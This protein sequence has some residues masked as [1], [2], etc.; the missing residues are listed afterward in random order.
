LRISIINTRDAIRKNLGY[1]ASLPERTLR[2]LA[3]SLGGLAYE[4][5]E[6]LLPSWLRRSR[7][8]RATVAGLLRIL[9]ELVGGVS[10]ALPPDDVG[11]GEFAMRKAAGT[12]IEVAGLLT[13]GWSP[14]WLL[15]VAADLTSG[16]RTYL[17][18]LV[19][20]LQRDGLLPEDADIASVEELLDTLEGASGLMAEMMD[21]PPLN[22]DD[23]RK[24]WGELRG[25]ATDLPDSDRLAGIYAQLGQAASRER[26][27]LQSVSSLIGAGALRAGVQVGQ[28][29]IFDYYSEA[30]RTINAEGSQAFVRRVTKPYLAAA[31]EHFDPQR[32]TYTQRSGGYLRT[33]FGRLANRT[34][35]DDRNE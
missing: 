4:L 24:S 16:T 31:L 13:M 27:S 10:D 2:A 5:T 11:V 30:L 34:A 6:A 22:V 25:K 23:M 12:G 18:V 33:L 17:R 28:V 7:L 32:V 20:E 1:F 8:Y 21:V 9:I 14:L 26:R 29:Y 19:A 35:E 3:A 15:A